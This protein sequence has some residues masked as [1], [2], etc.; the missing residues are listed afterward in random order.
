MTSAVIGWKVSD[1]VQSGLVIAYSLTLPNFVG[2]RLYVTVG[3][4]PSVRPSV[5]L[6][7]PTIE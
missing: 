3:W 1:I 5:R 6:S 7:V 2:K 4:G